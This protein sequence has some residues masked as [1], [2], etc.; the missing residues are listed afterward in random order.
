LPQE[1]TYRP[2]WNRTVTWPCRHQEGSAIGV[3]L[4][5]LGPDLVA[6]AKQALAVDSALVEIADERAREAWA[7]DGGT[8]GVCPI[9]TT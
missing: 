8:D 3:D 5:S 9:A 6:V 4:G 1:G 2:A 7:S